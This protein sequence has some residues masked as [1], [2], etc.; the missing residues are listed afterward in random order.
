M[1]IARDR[2]RRYRTETPQDTRHL[3]RL[4]ASHL[5]EGDVI[6]LSGGLGVGKTQLTSGIAQGLGDTRPVR[7]PTFAIQSIH[8]GGRLPLFHFDLYRLEHARQ[9]EDTGIFDV[10]AIEGA[11]VLEWGER[12]QEELVDEYLSVLITRCGETTRSI[13]LEAHGARAEQ[14]AAS[15]D[16]ALCETTPDGAG[17][18][19]E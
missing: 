5:I 10:L 15:V 1:S 9:L 4:I 8:D 13:A 14:L 12:F 2:A 3:G 11:C 19:H 18:E 7:S 17:D 6:I 16:A